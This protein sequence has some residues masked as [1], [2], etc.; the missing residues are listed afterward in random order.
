MNIRYSVELAAVVS[1]RSAELIEGPA[2][3]PQAPL[4]DLWKFSR[5]R[6]HDWLTALGAPGWASSKRAAE[7]IEAEGMPFE[8]APAPSAALLEEVLCSD[9]LMRVWLGVLCAAAEARRS[10]PTRRLARHLLLGHLHARCVALDALAVK[11]VAAPCDVEHL[12]RLRRRS[13]RW[14]DLLLSP[15]AGRYDIREFVHDV[16]RTRA[17]SEDGR[18]QRASL[19][20]EAAWHLT[21]CSIRRAFPATPPT[22][23][24][25][26]ACLR[27]IVASI[28]A[29]FPAESLHATLAQR[30]ARR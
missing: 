12:N 2:P 18:N 9:V 1:K 11:R 13:E 15:L 7:G 16:H 28:G 17:F 29:M 26:T 23:G 5:L 10:E 19:L 8:T 4:K 27:K 6:L 3:L 14:T 22:S 24:F 30:P 21:L 25:R 20:D